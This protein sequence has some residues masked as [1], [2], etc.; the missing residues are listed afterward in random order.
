MGAIRETRFDYVFLGAGN[1]DGRVD[2]C[3][4]SLAFLY[5]TRINSVDKGEDKCKIIANIVIVSY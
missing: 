3:C 1:E 4:I 5:L 2:D